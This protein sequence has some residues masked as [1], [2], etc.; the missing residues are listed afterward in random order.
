MIS[1]HNCYIYY[2]QNLRL[3]KNF[4]FTLIRGEENNRNEEFTRN[5]KK[6]KI[7]M[8]DIMKTKSVNYIKIKIL[9]SFIFTYN[10]QINYI[11]NKKN[12]SCKLLEE[13]I[14]TLMM[15]IHSVPMQ[16]IKLKTFC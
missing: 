8:L 4:P 11:W 2:W 15:S 9:M 1:Y 6:F 5:L 3:N 14:S 16:H 10:Y 13:R 7:S 12:R